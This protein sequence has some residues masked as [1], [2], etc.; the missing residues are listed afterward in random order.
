MLEKYIIPMH[1]EEIRFTNFNIEGTLLKTQYDIVVDINNKE[2]DMFD[3]IYNN[4][5]SMPQNNQYTFESQFIK[6]IV[7][8]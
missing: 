3:I 1:L 7:E 8:N 5:V 4:L 2:S 6:V